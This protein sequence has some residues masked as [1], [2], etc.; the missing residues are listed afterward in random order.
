MSTMS[1]TAM[2]AGSG[3]SASAIGL[4]A[5]LVVCIFGGLSAV[6]AA[7]VPGFWTVRPV[8]PTEN[9]FLTTMSADGST[10]A[11]Y[12]FS[13]TKPFG[14]QYRGFTWTRGGGQVDVP[15]SDDNELIPTGLSGDGQV[16]V[17]AGAFSDRV[18]SIGWRKAGAAPLERILPLPDP[19]PARSRGPLS[20]SRDGRVISGNYAIDKPRGGGSDL[21]SYVWTAETGPVLLDDRG[22]GFS[23]AHGISGDGRTVVGSINFAGAVWRDGGPAQMLASPMPMIGIDWSGSV[24]DFDGRCIAGSFDDGG[25]INGMVLWRDGVPAILGNPSGSFLSAAVGIA[26]GGKTIALNATLL[27]AP[28]PEVPFLWQQFVGFTRLDTYLLSLGITIEPGFTMVNVRSMS[29]DGLTFAGWG[30]NSA[31]EY[32]GFVATVPTMGGMTL[33]ALAGLVLA[34]RRRRSRV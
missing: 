19:L 7:P 3:R 12:T 11:G 18:A 25:T 26:D 21:R 22:S 31:G 15:G 32:A 27:T 13:P 6:E 23:N 8:V 17:G 29:S 1:M 10:A 16:I 9:L 28:F 20:V 5:S 30:R 24:V 34:A 14:D 33:S 2:T 4:T